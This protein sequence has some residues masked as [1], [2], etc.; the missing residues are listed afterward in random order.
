M[1]I[2]WPLSISKN[3][4]TSPA[5]NDQET[6]PIGTQHWGTCKSCTHHS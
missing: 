3:T 1:D 2:Y 4:D 5:R 6:N